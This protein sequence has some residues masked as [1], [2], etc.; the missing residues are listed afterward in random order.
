MQILAA[1]VVKDHLG[2]Q[3]WSNVFTEFQKTSKGLLSELNKHYKWAK[4]TEAE[5]H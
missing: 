4:G 3:F 5:A 1:E 2:L